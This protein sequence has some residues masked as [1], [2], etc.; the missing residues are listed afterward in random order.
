MEAT[1][2]L[3]IIFVKNPLPGKVKTRLAK[4]VGE[5]KALE[6]Y[7]QL[8]KYTVHITS[9]AAC[10]KA[11]FYSDFIEENDCWPGGKYKKQVQQGIDLGGRMLQAFTWAFQQR[12][13]QVVIIGSDCPQLSTSIIQESFEQL[14][15]HDV[16]IGPAADGGYYLLG[17]KKLLP[18]L[19]SNK[20]WS[21]ASVLTDTITDLQRLGVSFKQ[22]PTLHDVDE[23][24]D[25]Y[26]LIQEMPQINTGQ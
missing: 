7:L 2:R 3:L 17:M 24:K 1:R 16:V 22:L 8:L 18:D 26:L 19:F 5:H 9:D 12:Y 20:T 14:Q 4:T 11:V 15:A 6:I 13:G 21:S 25:L 10:D 23:E